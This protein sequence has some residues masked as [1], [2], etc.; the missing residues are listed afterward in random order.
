MFAFSVL[1]SN[2]ILI[3]ILL[4]FTKS[5]N[6][7]KIRM[8]GQICTAI[9]FVF[10]V[11]FASSYRDSSV[12]KLSGSSGCKAFCTSRD[13]QRSYCNDRNVCICRSCLLSREE[14]RE[15][16]LKNMFDFY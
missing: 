13:C 1:F 11:S 6:C 3:V 14:E 2:D 16:F 8:R 10:L 7:I 12:C 15:Q 9:F 4:L 5:L